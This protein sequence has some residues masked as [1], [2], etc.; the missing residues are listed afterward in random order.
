MLNGS[1][2][3]TVLPSFG[4]TADPTLAHG[5]NAHRG[6]LYSAEVAGA[7]GLPHTRLAVG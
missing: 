7:H 6:E 3:S 4:H 5:L 1:R 2:T